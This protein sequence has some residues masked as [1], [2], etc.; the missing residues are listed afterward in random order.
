MTRHPSR[1]GMA[2]VGIVV[3]LAIIH[4]VVIGS[5]SSGARESD[6]QTLRLETL[7]AFLAADSGVVVWIR[8]DAAGETIDAGETVDIGTER[9]IYVSAPDAGEA[10]TVVI[11]GQSG[12][13]RRR[14]AVDVETP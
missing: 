9:M 1:R 5:V 6:V 3:L 8:M 2:V 11:E 4:I 14:V 10:G 12:R 13:A 7:R